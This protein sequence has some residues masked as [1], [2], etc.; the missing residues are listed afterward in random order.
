MVR[1]TDVVLSIAF[2]AMG[3]LGIT[4]LLPVLQT[5]PAYVNIGEIILGALGLLV[6]IYTDQAAEGFRQRRKNAQDRKENV[7]LKKRA[8]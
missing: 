3:I 8:V 4:G 5:Y 2:L 1:M 6:G 7:Q